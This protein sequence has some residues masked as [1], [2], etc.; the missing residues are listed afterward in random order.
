VDRQTDLQIGLKQGHPAQSNFFR[1]SLFLTRSKGFGLSDLREDFPTLLHPEQPASRTH[2]VHRLLEADTTYQQARV[3]PST[4]FF[5]IP[6]FEN[7]C[8]QKTT[9]H[10]TPVRRQQCT[11][12]TAKELIEAPLPREHEIATEC[13]QETLLHVNRHGD[14]TQ[15]N[16][17]GE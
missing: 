7:L 5:P 14:R 15:L 8:D 12:K 3:V 16:E 6:T 10:I 2:Q 13:M 1:Q 11:F 4:L 9:S 17:T